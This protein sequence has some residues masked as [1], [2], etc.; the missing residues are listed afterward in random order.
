MQGIPVFKIC[1]AGLLALTLAACSSQ[2]S[3]MPAPNLYTQPGAPPLFENLPAG[4]RQ[5]A[6]SPRLQ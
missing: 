1:T 5:L 6:A 4:V 2:R 3:L